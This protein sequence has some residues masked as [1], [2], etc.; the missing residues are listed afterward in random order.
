MN[1][2]KVGKYHTLWLA[3]LESERGLPRH[4]SVLKSSNVNVHQLGYVK[5]HFLIVVSLS[6][7]EEAQKF[8][9]IAYLKRAG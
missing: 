7:S 3:P 1:Y 6:L 8:V 2:E 9:L 4:K 5:K